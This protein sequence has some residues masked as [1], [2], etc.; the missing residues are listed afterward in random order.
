MQVAG[1]GKN[2]LIARAIPAPAWSI[3]VSTLR[4]RENAD[5]SAACICAELK[6]ADSNYSSVLLE[7][8]FFLLDFFFGES[9]SESELEDFLCFDDDDFFDELLECRLCL[10]R[11]RSGSW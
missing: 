2:F 11:A 6:T 5:C 1:F 9:E 7:L 8:D 3:S 4:L 10:E